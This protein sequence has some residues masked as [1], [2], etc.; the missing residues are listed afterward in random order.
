[1]TL[2]GLFRI[3]I[4]IYSL[5]CTAETDRALQRNSAPRGASL[6]AQTVKSLSAMLGTQVQSLGW[7]DPLDGKWLC[8]SSIAA[9]RSPW[10]GILVG[11][12]L[13]GGTESDTTEAA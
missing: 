8:T 13:Q 10:T 5:S 3:L 7:E 9:W 4:H 12:S 11:Y 6:V 2:H 1:M